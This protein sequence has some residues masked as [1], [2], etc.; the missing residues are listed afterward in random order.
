[1]PVSGKAR[2]KNLSANV[3]PLSGFVPLLP[4][5]ANSCHGLSGFGA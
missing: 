4:N 1:M 2:R 3:Q 5:D